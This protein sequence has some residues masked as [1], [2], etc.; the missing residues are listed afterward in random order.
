[1]LNRIILLPHYVPHV[2]QSP[3]DLLHTLLGQRIEIDNPDGE[4]SHGSGY[5]AHQQVQAGQCFRGLNGTFSRVVTESGQ[6]PHHCRT[7]HGASELLRHR[8]GGEDEPRRSRPV[9][10]LGIV[11]DIGIHAPDERRDDTCAYGDDHLHQKHHPAT[12]RR[13]GQVEEENAQHGQRS[14]REDVRGL[15]SQPARQGDGKHDAC[16]VGDFPH[17]EE[18]ACIEEDGDVAQVQEDVSPDVVLEEI[19]RRGATHGTE[20]IGAQRRT[21]EQPPGHVGEQGPEVFRYGDG[22]QALHMF[23]RQEEAEQEDDEAERG[24]HHHGVL[25]R[26]GQRTGRLLEPRAKRFPGKQGDEAAAVGE[27]HAVG[28]EDGLRVRIVRHHAEHGSVGDVDGRV[29]GHHQDIGDVCPDQFAGRPE[30][31]RG[32]HQYAAEGEGKGHPEQVGAVFAPPRMG[33]VGNDAHHGVG[34]GVPDAGDQQQEARVRQAQAVDVGI[35]QR[36]IIGEYLPEHGG[37]H[38]SEAITDFFFQCCHAIEFKMEA[39]ISCG[40][41]CL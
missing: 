39:G 33:A 34:D 41:S 29:D 12:E 5:P 25:P 11:G 21:D 28:G 10:Q 6:Y 36:Q 40:H 7:A 2:F 19:G 17:A 23:L 14:H 4:H 27:E 24:Y 15:L 3:V 8:G 9:L 26:V 37:R 30:V 32:E 1:M 13:A 38:V 35:E 22:G 16:H 20:E 31:G 18:E